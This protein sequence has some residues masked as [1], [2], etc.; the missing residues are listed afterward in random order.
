MGDL[1]SA[2]K[3]RLQQLRE[4]AYKLVL[5]AFH[6]TQ[7]SGLVRVFARKRASRFASTNRRPQGW[8]ERM[9]LVSVHRCRRSKS[10]RVSLRGSSTSPWTS[11][12]PSLTL[13][14]RALT[15]WWFRTAGAPGSQAAHL[16][17][18]SPPTAAAVARSN[19]RWWAKARNKVKSSQSQVNRRYALSVT[20]TPCP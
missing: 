14:K 1:S 15:S 17:H 12:K 10:C 3:Q 4:D 5:K 16:R 6:A 13:F 8:P 19:G 9:A 20:L 7:Q 2:H 11:K 18:V